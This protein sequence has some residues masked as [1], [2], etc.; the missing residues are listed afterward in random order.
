MSK[1]KKPPVKSVKLAETHD[2]LTLTATYAT[3]GQFRFT[4]GRRGETLS[5][6]GANPDPKVAGEEMKRFMEVAKFLP[7]EKNSERML[8][9]KSLA[10]SVNS[11]SELAAA[12]VK[13]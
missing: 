7:G 6:G 12:L 5:W 13:A 11:M 10:E 1:V 4:V 9:L 3:G 2:R 8:R